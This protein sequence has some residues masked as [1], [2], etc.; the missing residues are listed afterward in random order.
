MTHYRLTETGRETKSFTANNQA[1]G[2]Y[3]FMDRVRQLNC[4]KDILLAEYTE[5]GEF[6]Q[7]V[8]FHKKNKARLEAFHNGQKVR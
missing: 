3:A 6:V 4:N 7:T 5:A 1:M 2:V 8:C